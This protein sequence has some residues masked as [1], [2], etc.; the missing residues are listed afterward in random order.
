MI[1]I[2]ITSVTLSIF[3]TLV[4]SILS[5]AHG[6]SECYKF[7][8]GFIL[9]KFNFNNYGLSHAGKINVDAGYYS[10]SRRSVLTISTDRRGIELLSL[11]SDEAQ[12]RELRSTYRIQRHPDLS[13][14]DDYGSRQS[15]ETIN[16]YFIFQRSIAGKLRDFVGVE[17][18]DRQ[19]QFF[20]LRTFKNSYGFP[21][22]SATPVYSEMIP[23][24]L[25]FQKSSDL[26]NYFKDVVELGLKLNLKSTIADPNSERFLIQAPSNSLFAKKSD[27]DVEVDTTGTV[28]FFHAE[29]DL[30]EQRRIVRS[31]QLPPIDPMKIK[32][33]R[34]EKGS[35]MAIHWGSSEL[36]IVNAN[37]SETTDRI[38]TEVSMFHKENE[39]SYEA[40]FQN[41]TKIIDTNLQIIKNVFGR[42]LH[43]IASLWSD[44]SFIVY[45]FDKNPG[46][47]PTIKPVHKEQLTPEGAAELIKEKG[48]STVVKDLFN[49]YFRETALIINPTSGNGRN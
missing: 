17:W 48:S 23:S 43:Y 38:H 2:K 27:L 24:L 25:Q 11:T 46:F 39:V 44:G 18:S 35:Y 49:T 15:T 37:Y 42:E 7:Y 10:P 12:Y 32:I 41:D 34:P 14:R 4:L 20:E 31:E 22:E 33:N 36:Y 40:K 29:A 26:A 6:N 19:V 9:T 28:T 8:N 3:L 5:Q 45:S 30:R 16:K 47:P 13:S 1:K 21:I